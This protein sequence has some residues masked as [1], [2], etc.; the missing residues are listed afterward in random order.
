MRELEIEN[1]KLKAERRQ[2]LL[3]DLNLQVSQ[4]LTEKKTV[5]SHVH[6]AIDEKDELERDNSQKSKL[7]AELQ[8]T[9]QMGKRESVSIESK[10]MVQIEDFKQKYEQLVSEKE[11]YSSDLTGLYAKIEEGQTKFFEVKE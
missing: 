9:I 5:E 2:T 11:S 10:Y 3:E 4:L 7:I 6:V 1:L 8:R